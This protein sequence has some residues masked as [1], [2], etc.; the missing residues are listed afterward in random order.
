MGKRVSA[1]VLAL[2]L[3]LA[4][5]PVPALAA[6]SD[7]VIEDGVLT[8]YKGSGGDVTVPDGVTGIGRSAF[9]ACESLTS[10]TIPAGVTSIGDWAFWNCRGLTSLTIPEGVTVIGD[11]A[12]CN[13]CSLPQRVFVASVGP[14]KKL[15]SPS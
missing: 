2:V 1:V 14:S 4:L 10:L 7:F 12:F 9:Y 11:W 3:M 15:S 13:C 8:K 5:V 6:D